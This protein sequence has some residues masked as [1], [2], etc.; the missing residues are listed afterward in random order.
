[1]NSNRDLSGMRGGVLGEAKDEAGSSI[2]VFAVSENFDNH[3][4][5]KKKDL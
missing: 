3:Y 4:E 1:M 5:D 2:K